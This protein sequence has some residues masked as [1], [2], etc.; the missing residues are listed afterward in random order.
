MYMKRIIFY[1]A[2]SGLLMSTWACGEKEEKSTS[3]VSVFCT[4]G[5]ADEITINSATLSGAAFASGAKTPAGS[6]CFFCSTNGESVDALLATGTKIDAGIVQGN[7]GSFSAVATNLSPASTYYYVAMVSFDGKEAYGSVKSFTTLARPTE[8]IVTAEADGITESSA[9]LYGYADIER[10]S[11]S[12][13]FGIIVSTQPNP[14]QDNGETYYSYEIDRNNKYYVE[15]AY[16]QEETTYYYKAFIE[17]G[18]ILRVGEVKSFTTDYTKV[19]ELDLFTTTSS[20]ASYELCLTVSQSETLWYWPMPEN[21]IIY[22][23][24]AKWTSNNQ[25]VASVGEESGSLEMQ[26]WYVTIT[27]KS[28][29]ETTIVATANDSGNIIAECKVKVFAKSPVPEAI[30]L[31]TG[32]KWASFNLGAAAPE[33]YGDNYAWGETWPKDKYNWSTYKW[34]KG[35]NNKLTRYCPSD[36]TTFWGGTGK[37]DNKEEFKD[38][39]YADDAARCALGGKWRVPTN[40]EWAKLMGCCS[41]IWTDNYKGTG[42]K[43]VIVTSNVEGYAGK[44]I[45]LPATDNLPVELNSNVDI[46]GCY[47]T[48][49]LFKYTPSSADCM[50]YFFAEGNFDWVELEGDRCLGFSI[51]PVTE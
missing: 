26:G 44:S 5:D 24:G 12:P 51:R 11:G 4:T 7:G 13:K 21:A 31:G 39:N 41:T 46:A 20:D 29:G 43:G 35:N 1:L 40:A 19:T 3:S 50:I 22:Y 38:Y 18:K 8:I 2:L 42:V 49:S 23:K 47:W 37:P 28:V 32:I 48:S 9:R 34:C 45:F 30:D 14:N 17:D 15:V 25:S 6:A 16:L 27:G 36:K 10:I 33:G